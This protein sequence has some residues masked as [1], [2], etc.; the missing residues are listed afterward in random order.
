M[1][2]VRE[3]TISSRANFSFVNKMTVTKQP[4][5]LAVGYMLAV[6]TA[7]KQSWLWYFDLYI[8]VNNVT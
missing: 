7:L 3:E 5:L 1:T 6:W 4:N 2:Y 8:G